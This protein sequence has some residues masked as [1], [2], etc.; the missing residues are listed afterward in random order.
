MVDDGGGGSR[1]HET[2]S[3]RDSNGSGGDGRYSEGEG[4]FASPFMREEER[5]EN[6]RSTVA[7]HGSPIPTASTTMS[8]ADLSS[9]TLENTTSYFRGEKIVRTQYARRNS[10]YTVGSSILKSFETGTDKE[11]G[12]PVLLEATGGGHGWRT[13]RRLTVIDGSLMQDSERRLSRGSGGSF[14]PDDDDEPWTIE[15]SAR[16]QRNR[17]YS[18]TDTLALPRSGQGSQDEPLT[19]I[20]HTSITQSESILGNDGK[21][22]I[23]VPLD[24]DDEQCHADEQFSVV[25]RVTNSSPMPA[26]DDANT[27]S[28]ANTSNPNL[29]VRPSTPTL[30]ELTLASNI[31][32]LPDADHRKVRM[33]PGLIVTIVENV[34]NFDDE[35][36]NAITAGE[37]WYTKA[38]VNKFRTESNEESFKE[39]LKAAQANLKK[40][41]VKVSE[42]DERLLASYA[43]ECSRRIICSGPSVYAIGVCHQCVCVAPLT[44]R[45]DGV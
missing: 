21:T 9:Y 35:E 18:Y 34:M 30:E 24:D 40:L 22:L 41:G 42:R 19:E 16:T 38:E 10:A 26:T 17:R 14:N 31:L 43:S 4:A 13:K 36:G 3:G 33:H 15:K 20:L 1:D 2:D 8:K 28:A 29:E 6:G 27:A 11:T 44:Q 5:E 37:I 32:D 25:A 45:L 23:T 39:E 12:L 7:S